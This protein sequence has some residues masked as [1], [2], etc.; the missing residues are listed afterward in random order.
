MRRKGI[1]LFFS[2]Q[3][4]KEK[5]FNCYKREGLGGGGVCLRLFRCSGKGVVPVTADRWSL[6]GVAY[7]Y[8]V[9]VQ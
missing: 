7:S 4:K 6:V 5:C 2:Q 3:N 8:S 1:T 9:T